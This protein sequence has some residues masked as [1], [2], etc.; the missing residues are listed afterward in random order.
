M[1][2][3]EPK[4]VILAFGGYDPT[5]GAGVLMDARAIAAS[6][7]HPV[8]V[9]S[10]L[11]LQSTATFDRVVPVSRDTIDRALACANLAHRI[12]G[13]KVGMI[14]TRAAADALLA[15]LD[16]HPGLPVV[17]D[18]VIRATSGGALLAKNALPAYRLLL[19]RANVLT[20]NLPEIEKLLGR[21]LVRFEDGVIAARDLS[22]DTGA[23][24]VLKGGHFAW[25]GKRGVDIVYDN[26][27]VT[28]LS[29]PRKLAPRDAHGT[30][31]AFASALATRLASGE[32][33]AMAAAAAKALVAGWIA[34][35]FKSAEGRWTL[36]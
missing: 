25:K 18:P 14:G 31:C 19:L 22:E 28:L 12:V 2:R 23:A 11:A 17:L 10:C 30:G 5:S 20:P 24:V 29:P 4:P 9:P 21:P 1:G 16:R 26:G 6:G 33:L 35:G 27:T 8:A 34:G 36:S 3:R 15:F 7:G 32:P 13:V